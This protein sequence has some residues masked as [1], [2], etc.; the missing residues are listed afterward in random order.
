MIIKA[1]EYI[2]GQAEK[3]PVILTL[4]VPLIETGCTSEQKIIKMREEID[5]LLNE[6]CVGKVH[7]QRSSEE[8]MD[9]IQVMAGYLLAINRE[10]YPNLNSVEQVKNQFDI[11]SALHMTKMK[12]RAAERNWDV[13][14]E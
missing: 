14:Y 11:A 6:F 7:I 5:E 1:N 3:Q 13:V 2:Y 4:Q 12:F 8:L 9:V 10:T